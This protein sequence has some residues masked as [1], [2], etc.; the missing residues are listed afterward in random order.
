MI[1]S[2]TQIIGNIGTL[3][4]GT[5]NAGTFTLTGGTLNTG[6]VV[7]NG[8]TVGT[9]PGVGVVTTVTTVS[10][11]TNGSVKVTAGTV[12]SGTINAG[13]ITNQP[14]PATQVLSA[15]TVSTG[16]IGTLV[17]AIGA[18][19]GIYPTNLIINASSG[20]PDVVVS[21]GLQASGNQVV[22]RGVYAATGGAVI[23][24]PYPSFYGTANSALTWN[25]LSG[26]GTI[27]LSVL[28][29]T[30]GTP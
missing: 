20:T 23:P 30:K 10:N 22:N 14:F 9:V 2:G 13:T 5:I 28:Y 21:F 24:F 1:D 25:V 12:N 4:A 27:S 29:S 6:T 19:T 8:G 7:P 16:T 11:L 18:G 17:A 26:A 15:G 3:V